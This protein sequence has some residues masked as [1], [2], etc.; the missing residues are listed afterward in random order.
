MTE[1]WLPVKGYEGRYSVSDYGRVRSEPRVVM[2]SNG[3]PQTVQGRILTTPIASNG[4]KIASL[5]NG[6]GRVRTHPVHRLVAEAFIGPKPEG[7]HTC[8]T[9]GDPLNNR[10]DNLRYDT[11]AENMRDMVR[12]GRGNVAKTHCPQGH[13]YAR[14]NMY[15]YPRKSGGLSRHCRPCAIERSKA[16]SRRMQLAEIGGVYE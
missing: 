12:H 16:R 4:R 5:R 10:V 6:A 13:P 3:A 8:H 1:R 14:G 11:Q 2:R 15:V 9:D 7:W